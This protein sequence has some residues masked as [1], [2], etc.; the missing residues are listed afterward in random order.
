M[1]I[2]E[3]LD[4][5]CRE[6]RQIVRSLARTPV[7]AL[8]A[9]A[10]LGLAIGATID[11]FAVANDL[12]LRRPAWR[13]ADEIVLLR[14]RDAGRGVVTPT[15]S[16]P[17]FE[18]IRRAVGGEAAAASFQVRA[19]T[20]SLVN[21]DSGIRVEAEFVSPTYMALIGGGAT[22]G[23]GIQSTATEPRTIV[24]GARLARRLFPTTDPIGQTMH[25][26]GIP[27]TVIGTMAHEY[28]GLSGRGD[29]WIPLA[30]APAV[31]GSPQALN[32][33]AWTFEVALRIPGSWS[34][35]RRALL[36]GRLEAV[37]GGTGPLTAAGGGR[38]Q[39]G[40]ATSRSGARLEFAPARAQ[41]VEPGIRHLL[42]TLC[43]AAVCVLL[44]ACTNVSSLSAAR[45]ASRW[46]EVGVRRAL[47]AS[48]RR[49]VGI[50]FFESGLVA[51]AS[52]AAG[53]VLAIVARPFVLAFRPLTVGGQPL[54]AGPSWMNARTVGFTVA[55]TLL[56]AALISLWPALDVA[57]A[58][59]PATLGIRDRLAR[60]A[61][62]GSRRLHAALSSAQ[63]AIAFVLASG[64]LLFAVSLR[65]LTALDH[66]F[67]AS[68]LVSARVDLPRTR[69]DSVRARLV[70]E[71]VLGA[72]APTAGVTDVAVANAAPLDASDLT[73]S[74]AIDFAW[75]IGAGGRG[76]SFEY[77][78][79]S[80][81]YFRALSIGVDGRGFERGP[82]GGVVP[83]II[84]RSMARRYWPDESPVGKT[85]REFYLG[86][87]AARWT[88]G[89]V[90]GVAPD[91][92]YG[93]PGASI[94][95][96]IYVRASDDPPHRAVLLGRVSGDVGSAI[97][98][99]RASVRSVD[100][101]LVVYDA[102]SM[103]ARVHDVSSR[104]R[105]GALVLSAYAGVAVV[106]AVIGVYSV[107]ALGV[108]QRRGELAVR[109]ALGA[110][111]RTVLATVLGAG[112][113]LSAIGLTVGAIAGVLAQRVLRAELFGV[114]AGDP[115]YYLIVFA[116][117]AIAALGASLGPAIAAT[118]LD[119]AAVLKLE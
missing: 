82:A 87:L 52:A 119:P 46:T 53:L 28:V 10:S 11:T 25:A 37:V 21:A 84:N 9:V 93:R 89:V 95:P 60:T 40:A 6:A 92:Q 71:Q 42:W 74:G 96:A 43:G 19:V 66:G 99:M 61:G 58:S 51:A 73:T 49:L 33:F 12:V 59:S 34:A 54:T 26:N 7:Y 94:P 112:I 44:L 45:L 98:A 103:D 115:R 75:P 105:F 118:R 13:N 14:R 62:I 24:L 27:L 77:H 113:R 85:I 111:P 17:R 32:Q 90:V 116:T 1:R 48:T 83:V 4:T 3:L 117:L 114:S 47:G 63:L 79:V 100:P 20:L 109:L 5:L 69:Y 2:S 30:A 56:V 65:S 81:D 101:R 106:I 102:H 110:D 78:S 70:W 16:Q 18:D 35:E 104:T 57:R 36:A 107:M 23:R 76:T 8:G 72:L 50:A 41:L 64:A 29:A 91:V 88:G 15:W 67:M 22:R 86:N 97:G 31:L 38:D 108:I 68:R 39:A 55:V 80:D